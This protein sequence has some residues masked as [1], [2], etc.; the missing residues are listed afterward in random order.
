MNSH[1]TRQKTQ[2]P[3]HSPQGSVSSSFY[4]HPGSLISQ[5]PARLRPFALAALFVPNVFT[6]PTTPRKLL[7]LHSSTL[8][9]NWRD[10]APSPINS[11]FKI[12]SFVSSLTACSVPK[13][14]NT[15]V[16]SQIFVFVDLEEKGTTEDEMAG[17]HYQHSGHGFGW[18]PGVGDGQG[19]LVCCGS[20]GCKESDTTEQLH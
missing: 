12:D 3:K 14:G 10:P 20:W 18:T 8:C 19:G 4:P 17:W 7:I 9:S 2:T 1:S 5:A 11:P 13:C 16:C 6:S 15:T